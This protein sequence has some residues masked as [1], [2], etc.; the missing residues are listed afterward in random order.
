MSSTEW[1]YS[2]DFAYLKN[3][4]LAF[5]STKSILLQIFF[6]KTLLMTKPWILL[7][8]TVYKSK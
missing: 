8:R 7:I 6:V 5:I 4:V 1:K 2:N 3:T